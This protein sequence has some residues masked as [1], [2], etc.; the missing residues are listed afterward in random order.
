MKRRANGEGSIY[1]RKDGRWA[2]VICLQNGKRKSMYRHTQAEAV[3]ALQ[4]ANQAKMQGTLTTTRNETVE[5][6][7]QDWLCYRVQPRVRERTYQNYCET[8]TKHLLPTLGQIKLQQLT[9]THIQKLYD[10][11][12]QQQLSPRTIHHIHLILRRALDDAIR[13]HHLWQ[14]VCQDVVLPRQPK[15]HLVSKTLTFE[16]TK[17]LLAAAKG[18][19]LEALYVLALTTGMRQGELLALT[20]D[21]LDFATGKLHIRRSLSRSPQKGLVASEL[22]TVSSRRCIQLTMLA[23]DTLQHHAQIQQQQGT[24]SQ[25]KKEQWIFCNTQGK[26]LQ[27][28]NLIRSSFRPLLEKAGLPPMRFHD[29]RHTTATLLLSMGT[30]PK[31]VQELLGHSQITVTLEIYSHVLPS[32]QE[33]TMQKFHTWLTA[34]DTSSCQ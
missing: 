22:K 23:L 16:Q 18:D 17:Q 29:V 31:I 26:P 11:K 6:F 25:R 8:V 9:A 2:A 3:M 7:L 33:E 4:L 10:T 28:A 14:N 21:D 27:A 5:A 30:H 34:S 32:L 20:W 1:Q 12:R 15:G 19:E 13:L 24:G